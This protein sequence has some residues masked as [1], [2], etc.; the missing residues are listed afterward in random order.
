MRMKILACAALVAATAHAE[1]PQPFDWSR[2]L[3][4]GGTAFVHSPGN[5]SCATFIS[6]QA[7]V[8][9]GDEV[10]LTWRGRNYFS[11]GSH[12]VSW[13]AGFISAANV[14]D[15][16]LDIR[17]D[18]AGIDGWLRRWCEQHPADSFETAVETFVR[19]RASNYGGH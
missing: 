17:V 18:P 13:A 16:R 5:D 19:D 6:A 9:L 4:E 14:F 12:Y 3:W 11:D 2:P 1:G 15:H 10:R 7:D 8:R